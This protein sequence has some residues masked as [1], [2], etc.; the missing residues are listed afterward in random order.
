VIEGGLKNEYEEGGEGVNEQRREEGR[1]L[2]DGW[3][4]VDIG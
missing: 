2:F 4:I 3:L 1:R